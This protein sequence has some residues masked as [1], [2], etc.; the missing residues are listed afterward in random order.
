MTNINVLIPTEVY[1]YIMLQHYCEIYTYNQ[2]VNKGV[3]IKNNVV[4]KYA[5]VTSKGGGQEMYA[6]ILMSIDLYH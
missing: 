5:Y 3:F 2:V 1:N 4:E 6:V